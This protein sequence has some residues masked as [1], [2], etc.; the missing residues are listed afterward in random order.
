LGTGL[1]SLS[2]SE[3]VSQSDVVVVADVSGTKPIGLASV[4]VRG[5]TLLAQRYRVQAVALYRLMGSCPE[6]F[7]IELLLPNTST[8]YRSVK[9]GTRMLFL[10]RLGTTYIPANPYYPDFPALPSE[11]I[12]F[13][14]NDARELVFAELSAVIASADASSDDKWEVLTQSFAIPDGDKLFV[15]D[16]LVGLRSTGD[17]DLRRRIQAELIGRNDISEFG[18]V[19]DALLADTISATQKPVLLYEIGQRLKNEKAVPGL[20]QLLQSRD[21]QVRVASAQALWH[22]ASA[23]S[24]RILTEALNDQNPDV[25]YYAI[26]G[27]ADITGELQWGPSPGEYEEHETKYLSYWRD[28][29]AS[30]LPRDIPK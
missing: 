20:A 17:L 13:H 18:D 9:L 27:L 29:A 25:R 10:K 23:S 30:N 6:Q 4:S 21:P 24:V 5:V 3:L 8:G 11:P 19:R 7:S 2:I 28:W 1:P 12:E 16:L 14:G 15:N 22:I 26:R